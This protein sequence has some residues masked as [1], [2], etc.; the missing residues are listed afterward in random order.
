M[1]N[2]NDNRLTFIDI[3]HLVNICFSRYNNKTCKLELLMY[4]YIYNV[5]SLKNQQIYTVCLSHAIHLYL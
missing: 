4:V 5:F 3:A 2:E 1:Q